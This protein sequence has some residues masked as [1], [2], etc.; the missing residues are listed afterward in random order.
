MVLVVGSHLTAVGSLK[1][2]A[3]SSAVWG[4]EVA[5]SAMDECFCFL[6]PQL[7]QLAELDSVGEATKADQ[8]DRAWG[9]VC[10]LGKNLS[11]SSW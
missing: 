6:V 5:V 2:F 9:G 3:D 8:A 10:A 7:I 4:D 11:R 1:I